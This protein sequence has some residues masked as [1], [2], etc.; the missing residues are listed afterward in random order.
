MLFSDLADGDSDTYNA[1]DSSGHLESLCFVHRLCEGDSF[2]HK[3]LHADWV[4]VPILLLGQGLSATWTVSFLSGAPKWP[5]AT[6]AG[7]FL[8]KADSVLLH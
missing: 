5:F 1:H 2:Q 6:P 3:H 8:P 7:R 4:N